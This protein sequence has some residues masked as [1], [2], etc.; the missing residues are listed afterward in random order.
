MEAW[1]IILDENVLK[2]IS[3]V[4]K[5]NFMWYKYASFLKKANTCTMYFPFAKQ[6]LWPPLLLF[7]NKRFVTRYPKQKYEGLSGHL[8][9]TE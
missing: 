9:E 2:K 5:T 7:C 6:L 8:K 4:S 3:V 1:N